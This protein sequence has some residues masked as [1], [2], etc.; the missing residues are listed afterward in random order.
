VGGVR[1]FSVVAILVLSFLGAFL[2]VSGPAGAEYDSTPQSNWGVQTKGNSNTI[3]QWAALAW[4][5]DQIDGTVFVGGNFLEVTN[6]SQ[7]A[8]QP[9]FAAFDAETG[10]FQPWFRPDL[11]SAVFAMQ[12]TPD[13]GL[14]VG[15]EID[16][17]NGEQIGSLVKIDPSTGEL[18][19]GW[20]TRVFG[21]NAV[22]RD[23]KLEADGWVYAVGSFTQANQGQ[24]PL[25]A[26]GAIR[27]DPITGDIDESWLPS[28][29]EG[30]AAWGVSR[31]KTQPVTYV[32]GFFTSVEGTVN[33]GGFV[34]LDDA[35]TVVQDRSIVPFNACTDQWPY[36]VQMYDVEATEAGH[37]WVGGVEHALYAIDEATG[38]LIQH[39]YTACNPEFNGDCFGNPWWG[40]EFQEIERVGDRIYATC[41]CWTDLYSHDELIFHTNPPPEATRT[42]I[43]SV[44]AFDVVTTD[45]ISSFAP[46]LTG[47]SGGFGVHVNPSDGCLW[48][49]GG[50]SSYGAP[51]G[52]QPAARDV[53]RLCDEAGPGPA[54]PTTPP[55]TPE[56]CSVSGDGNEVSIEW[57]NNGVAQSTI[58]F[59]AVDAG[60]PSWAGRV[61]TPATSFA[62]TAV[63]NQVS[64]FFVQ[65]VYEP[66][67]RSALVSC[68]AVD[69]L[70]GELLPATACATSIGPDGV[71]TL[72]WVG[73]QNAITHIVRRSVDGGP[74]YWRARIDEGATYT[75]NLIQPGRT[76]VFTVIA[77]GADGTEAE[78]TLCEPEV[79]IEQPSAGTVESCSA[80]LLADNSIQI[81][82]PEAGNIDRYI[83]RRSVNGGANY[84]RGR[85]YSVDQ[86]STASFL[87]TLTTAGSSYTFTV[88][89]I[90]IDNS[91]TGPV[92]CDPS[93]IMIALPEV[94]PAEQCTV[95][96]NGSSFDL[97]WTYQAGEAAA[98]AI[99]FRSRDGGPYGWRARTSGTQFE[100][101]SVSPSSTYEYQIR[102]VDEDSVRSEP[103]DCV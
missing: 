72:D 46:Q 51:G 66:G 13:G 84:W 101:F 80:T 77:R 37:I 32:A 55:P 22:V 98:D 49:V 2:L 88:E 14:L 96:D 75:D 92:T 42:T 41:H 67:Q 81:D 60:S 95:V 12:P 94:T 23:L 63:P 64:E 31:S 76:Y 27:F 16:T 19:P 26:G 68:G 43:K 89:S 6:G 97:T 33:T 100:D 65:H 70:P 50:Y 73:G 45:H 102:L 85:I 62:G 29:D 1:R 57:T 53:A 11:G 34:G 86:N 4:E 7:V 58:V 48:L 28:V 8:S 99:V 17:W 39:H 44:A 83:L 10:V 30:G 40:G 79:L 90:G 71:A 5:V 38:S 20:Q 36:C 78:G 24:G 82:W 74:A 47:D 87:D 21:G 25:P 69:L 9:Y 93:P 18:W 15:G 56:T 59:R 103:V 35:G 61:D 91:V 3:G 52:P 54:A